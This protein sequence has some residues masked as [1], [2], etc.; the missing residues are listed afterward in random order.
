MSEPSETYPV[1][2]PLLPD[3]EL[4][5]RNYRARFARSEDELDEVQRLRFDVFNLEL[6]EGLETSYQTG[7]DEDAFDAACHHLLVEN[8]EDESIVGTYR[9][10]TQE[11]AQAGL[12]F[13][14]AQEFELDEWPSKVLSDAV[15]LGRAC[16][17]QDHRS[18]PVLNLLWRGIGAYLAHNRRRYLF[19]CSSLTS[20][21]PQEGLSVMRYFQEKELMH[22]SLHVTPQ[23]EYECTT[24]API[25]TAA[26]AD[27]P[28]L[29]RVYIS[30]GA[31]ICGPPALDRAFKTI[32]FLTFYDIKTLDE[33]AARFFGLDEL[34]ATKS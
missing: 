10:Q 11:M 28:R 5:V 19:G 21:D 15:E 18:L 32:D 34:K 33:Q 12:G 27:I 9:M 29:M 20:Q 4:R 24:D 30:T 17:A 26:K 16:I 14:S 25:E 22:P 3:S 7:R 1:F 6:D 13:Y 8:L 23:P 2:E 31:R